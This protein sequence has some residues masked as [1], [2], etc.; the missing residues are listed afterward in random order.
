MVTAGNIAVYGTMDRW[1]KVVDATTGKALSIPCA[2]RLHRPADHLSGQRRQSIYRHAVGRRRLGGRVAN[3]EIDPQV[4]NG[5]LGYTGAMDDLPKS[6]SAATAFWC[7]PSGARR[8][9]HLLHRSRKA[10]PTPFRRR[11]LMCRWGQLS[12]AGWPLL[13]AIPIASYLLSAIAVAYADDGRSE[14]Y[15]ASARSEHAA[16]CHRQ[17]AGFRKASRNWLP[18]I[19]ARWLDICAGTAA[20]RLCPQ[21][22]CG[23]GMRRDHGH[24][25]L[26]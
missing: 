1:F 26:V 5:A 13:A 16:V 18:R 25:G 4:R 8:R 20:P 19:S 23:P 12:P 17:M 10:R 2:L 9:M 15:C 14:R 24:T 7:F 21:R 3:A 11:A 6:Q 22:P